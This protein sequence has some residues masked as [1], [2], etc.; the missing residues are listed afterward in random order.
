M[1]ARDNGWTIAPTLLWFGAFLVVGLVVVDGGVQAI[2][3]RVTTRTQRS[4][5]PAAGPSFAPAPQVAVAD[6]SDDTTAPIST[7]GGG[8]GS[9]ASATGSAAPAQGPLEDT[10]LDGS[11]S[12]DT[13]CK[14][15]AMDG[16]YQAVAAEK[17]GKLDVG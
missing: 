16:Y 12:S 7:G 10:C 8:A 4:A 1:S 9:A 3:D 15:W 2:A 5:A 14:R 17:S 13:A 11:G 6:D